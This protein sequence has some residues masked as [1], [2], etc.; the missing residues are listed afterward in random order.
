MLPYSDMLEIR[1]EMNEYLLD[2]R[3]LCSTPKSSIEM[4][5]FWDDFRTR[6]LPRI[7][8]RVKYCSLCSYMVEQIVEEMESL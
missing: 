4:N 6:R 5:T 2:Y 1:E 3:K 7:R 8:D